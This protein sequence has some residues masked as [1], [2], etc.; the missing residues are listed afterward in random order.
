MRNTTIDPEQF[1]KPGN[2][3]YSSYWNDRDLVLDYQKKD[4]GFRVLVVRVQ[5]NPKGGWMKIEEPRHHMTPPDH[6]H[7]SIIATGVAI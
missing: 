7:D 2:V 1:Y 6:R 3:V 5:P 4:Y